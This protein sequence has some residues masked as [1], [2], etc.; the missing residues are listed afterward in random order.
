MQEKRVHRRVPVEFT[1]VCELEDGTTIAG[2]ARDVSIGGMY[3]DCS[4]SL[5]FGTKLT[6]VGRLPTMKVEARLPGTVRWCKPDGLGVQFGLL[7][8]RE[9]HAIAQ[10]MQR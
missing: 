5:A 2:V 3:V 1:V 7:G 8:A 10:L 4:E 6:V 9:T